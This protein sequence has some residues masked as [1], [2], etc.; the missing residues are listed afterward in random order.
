[1]STSPPSGWKDFICKII[2]IKLDHFKQQDAFHYA[3]LFLYFY[4]VNH[5]FVVH[6]VYIN[7]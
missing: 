1:M 3:R 7:M 6:I 5:F 2:C 4:I